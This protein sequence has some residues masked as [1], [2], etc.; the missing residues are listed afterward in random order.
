LETHADISL[1]RLLR[2]CMVL[3]ALSDFDK[4]LAPEEPISIAAMEK[5]LNK[6]KRQRAR[7]KK[8]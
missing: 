2:L 4:V 5:A 3:H 7:R 1:Q 8:S 6:K